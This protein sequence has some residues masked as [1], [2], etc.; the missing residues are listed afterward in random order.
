MVQAD[1]CHEG[2]FRGDDIRGVQPPAEARLDDRGIDAGIGEPFEREAGGNLEE[3]QAV[4]DEIGL[5]GGQEVENVVLGNQVEGVARDDAGPFPEIHQVR[6]GV[7]ADAEA[8]TGERRREE[9]RDG[10]LAVGPGHVDAL[11]RPLGM[12]QRLAEGLH[13]CQARLVG[14]GEIRLLHRREPLEDFLEQRPVPGL[15]KIHKLSLVLISTQKYLFL[16][17]NKNAQDGRQST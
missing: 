17:T 5:P 6:G 3:G 7:Q 14:R 15:R 10:A 9:A 8:D 16:R 1:G 4:L 11:E 12:A 2:Q 13:A